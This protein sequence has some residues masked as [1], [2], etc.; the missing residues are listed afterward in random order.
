MIEF[1]DIIKILN[2]IPATFGGLLYIPQT[3]EGVYT[4]K[5]KPFYDN[6]NVLKTILLTLDFN[7]CHGSLK[8]MDAVDQF[9][10][11][12][13]DTVNF[14]FDA[15]YVEDNHSYPLDVHFIEGDILKKIK[16][17]YG[18]LL[19]R[20]GS[21]EHG[22]DFWKVLSNNMYAFV[23]ETNTM[24]YFTYLLKESFT[25]AKTSKYRIYPKSLGGVE[26]LTINRRI[27]Q[28]YLSFSFR[29]LRGN[30]ATL[31]RIYLYDPYSKTYVEEKYPEQWFESCISYINFHLQVISPRLESFKEKA[32]RRGINIPEL[33]N[34]LK[35]YSNASILEE[36][37]WEKK[38]SRFD[39]LL[40]QF[41]LNQYKT[42]SLLYF[43]SWSYIKSIG[44]ASLYCDIL[45][46]LVNRKYTYKCGFRIIRKGKVCF[47]R[48]I[49]AG[50]KD[51]ITDPDLP[52]LYVCFEWLFRVLYTYFDKLPCNSDKEALAEFL[53][54]R[55][56]GFREV[57]V[58]EEYVGISVF[59]HEGDSLSG[60]YVSRNNSFGYPWIRSF[61]YKFH[62]DNERNLRDLSQKLPS[63][64]PPVK[65]E[66]TS[67]KVIYNDGVGEEELVPGKDPRV[68]VTEEYIKI[69]RKI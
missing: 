63:L 15:T 58:S 10:E 53:G 2:D 33:P 6:Q 5:E 7:T 59:T 11:K 47:K 35:S 24:R 50:V 14:S 30:T 61:I 48:V 65:K 41:G 31:E 23:S 9:E 62:S 68:E 40:S 3:K 12:I 51:K 20:H 57:P 8:V 45:H 44:S 54:S 16:E 60:K 28:G 37:S 29:I 27:D 18:V 55:I 64:N 46:D 17:S 36:K 25:G 52:I 19:R 56:L 38:E 22:S 39:S 34:L 66:I 13:D 43:D 32:L 26:L 69:R 1:K 21:Q 4:F 67:V 49:F 42:K